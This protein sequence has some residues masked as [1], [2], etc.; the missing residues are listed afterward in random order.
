[1]NKELIEAVN[2]IKYNTNIDICKLQDD[3]FGKQQI[4]CNDVLDEAI[5]VEMYL[6]EQY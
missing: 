1:M 2:Y 4:I 6:N 5:L 3:M